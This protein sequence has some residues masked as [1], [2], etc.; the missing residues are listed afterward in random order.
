MATKSMEWYKTS[1]LADLWDEEAKQRIMANTP[2]F[3]MMW[4][5][6]TYD[7]KQTPD[8][9]E[10]YAKDKEVE[11]WIW[12]SI[13]PKMT[14]EE[15]QKYVDWLSDIQYWQMQQY[16]KQ[17]YSFEAAKALVENSNA[18][19]NPTAQWYGKYS[20]WWDSNAVANVAQSI[21]DVP[22]NLL[23]LPVNLL[24][25][26]AAGIA[27]RISDNDEEIDNA[28]QNQLQK[29]ENWGTL[30][31]VNREDWSY[32]IPNLV[33]DLWVTVASSFIPIPWVWAAKWAEFATKF[34]KFAKLIKAVWWAEEMYKKYPWIAK[35]LKWWTMWV[36]DVAIMNALEWEW[37][38]P[39]EALEWWLAWWVVEKWMWWLKKLSAYLETNW[40][41]KPSD[42]ANIIRKMNERWD[43]KLRDITELADF[44][45]EHWL[46]WTKQTVHDNAL[47]LGSDLKK[48]LMDLIKIA[49]KADAE[50]WITHH[51]P[52][53]DEAIDLLKQMLE[54]TDGSPIIPR[55]E[56]LEFF[57]E[58]IKKRW[59][60]W[61][62]GNN[63]FDNVWNYS[64][65]DLERLKEELDDLYKIYDD[66]WSVLEKQQAW[67]WHE[68]RKAIKEYIEKTLKDR[69]L[70]DVS[71]INRDISTAYEI[72][73]WV[74]DKSLAD[75]TNKTARVADTIT[76]WAWPV[77]W[78][79]LWYGAVK[80][81]YDWDIEWAIAKWAW[82]YLLNNTYLKTHI[83]SFL[84]R[85]TWTSRK[86]IQ[87]WIDSEWR[88]ALSK[89]ASEEVAKIIKN[90]ESLSK[91]IK[92]IAKQYMAQF[93]KESATV[94][95]QKWTEWM[96]DEFRD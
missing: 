69:N 58:M 7:T 26:W 77:A 85:M 16:H 10:K 73:N 19:S 81:L 13:W 80:D 33:A 54:K 90:D 6:T 43:W 55:K 87:Q 82:V 29:V 34:P 28:L 36:R 4:N 35:F 11:L 57:N 88:N 76:D 48:T 51:L 18:L 95:L 44:M 47:K 91:Q 46:V 67:R 17:W 9:I 64:L 38:T 45:T 96:V 86:E 42:A 39:L 65:S 22:L 74:A 63:L 1:I 30:P 20:T 53:A 79:A 60:G 62:K 66:A 12:K 94:W 41:L 14:D 3:N 56:Q 59:I 83:W 27:K 23:K 52:E 92:E 84:N 75:A 5:S 8:E 31:W 68:E 21:I 70:W 78:L 49:D 93:P 50:K 71:K 32:Q 61:T 89:E 15:K 25:K 2:W 24:Y 40:L 72:A 37:T